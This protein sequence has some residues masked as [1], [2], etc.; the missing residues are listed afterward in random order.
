MH[1]DIYMSLSRANKKIA[2]KYI[3]F[4]I[5]GKLG[6]TVPVLLSN[7]LFESINLILQFRNEAEIPAKNPYIFG[8]PGIKNQRYRY[9]RACN[10]LRKFFKEH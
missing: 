5:R 6:R 3:R 4:C 1:K 7:E 8:L 10:L 2:E 9:L